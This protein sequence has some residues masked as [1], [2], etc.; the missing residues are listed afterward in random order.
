[1]KVGIIGLPNVGKSSLFNLLTSAHAHVANFPFTTIDRNV[2]M[3]PI[4]DQRLDM[5]AQITRSPKITGAQIEFVDIAGLIEGASRGE[6]LGNTFLAHIRD[7]DVVLHVVR[8]FHDPQIPHIEAKLRPDHDYDIVRTELLLAD[9]ELIERRMEKTK[10]KAECQDECQYLVKIHEALTRGKA[11]DRSCVD[12]PLITAKKEIIV[13]NLDENTEYT[14][15]MEGYRLSVKMEEDIVDMSEG[16]KQELRA[17]IHAE[18][19]GIS[20]LIDQCYRSLSLI[21][22]YTI[23]GDETRAWLLKEGSSVLEAAGKIHSDMEKGFIKA[24]V[25][26]YKDFIEAKDF[27]AAQQAGMTKI[28]GKEYVVHDGDIILIKFRA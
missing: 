11:P 21:M 7:V 16:E 15:K 22:F 20:G 8:C 24:E 5:I 1:M 26:P 14:G 17:E 6:G 10:K 25:L 18:T 23:K 28:E 3:A 27:T 9:L 2:G 13:L 12:P 4:Y 19:A